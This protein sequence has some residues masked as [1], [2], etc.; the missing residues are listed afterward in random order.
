MNVL[1]IFS[2]HRLS[3]CRKNETELV[4]ISI[5]IA[6]KNESGNID[7]LVDSLRKLDYPLEMF[8]VIFVDDNSTDET[9]A[10]LKLQA[11]SIK[12]FSVKD[13]KE[14]GRSGKREALSLGIQNSKYPK[15]LVTD[16]DCRPE[17]NLLKSYSK[18]FEQGFD[19]LF[20]IAPFYQHSKLINRVSCFENLRNSIFSF[21]MASIGLPF[22]AAARNFGFS[23]N[24]FEALGGYSKTKDTTSGDD[25]LLLRE[26]VKQN[27][28]IGI[29]TEQESFVYSEAKWTFSEYLKQKARHTQTSFHYLKRHQIILGLWHLLNLSFL[30]SPILMF[31]NPLFGILLPAK[32]IIDF[33]TVKT[34]QKKFG[35]TFSLIEIFYLQIF[36]ELFLAIHFFNA[37]FSEIKWK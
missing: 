17:K 25:D 8:E 12:N 16:A 9:Y 5:V 7:Q 19:V 11:E 37:Q 28:K 30:F 24:A 31:F 27:M 18:K 15:I 14:T 23:R 2:L 33:A 3:K 4:N 22:S 32:L 20:G 13:L 6:A 34:N 36:Y 1:L 26:A 35:Y 29:V 10:R 21:S